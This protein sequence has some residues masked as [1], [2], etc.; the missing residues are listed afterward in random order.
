MQAFV[1]GNGLGSQWPRR[2]VCI[3]AGCGKW[4]DQLQAW[5]YWSGVA[6]A[7][8]PTDDAWNFNTNN[9]NQNNNDQN[10]EFYAL[11]VLPGG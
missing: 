6:Y 8:F 7:P 2:Q 11:A 4:A 3:A 10:N 5:A 9:G 1:P